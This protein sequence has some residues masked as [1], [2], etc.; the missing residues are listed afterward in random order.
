[1]LYDH[2]LLLAYGS[3]ATPQE[4]K[5]YFESLIQA[6]ELAPDRLAEQMEHIV[7]IGG[8]VPQAK[9]V[10]KL[11]EKLEKLLLA[12]GYQV[13]VYFGMRHGQPPITNAL[14]E[15]KKRKGIRG[16]AVILSPH[17]SEMT[18]ERYTQAVDAA[19]NAVGAQ[20]VQYEYL[21]VKHNHPLFIQAWVDQARQAM[22]KLT[23]EQREFVHIVFTGRAIPRSIAQL[24]D[25]EKEVT[26]TTV[27]VAKDLAHPKWTLAYQSR[28][29]A[30]KETCTEPEISS[31]IALFNKEKER[32]VLVVP[33][34]L[35]A[36]C[37]ETRYDL[38]VDSR[39]KA[40]TGG[41]GFM[42]ADTPI[43][44]PKFVLSILDMLVEKLK[45]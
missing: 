24:S 26:A 21:K 25:Y 3:P 5:P 23:L 6:K 12:L 30:G 42:R 2:V 4:V 31:V 27:Q 44:H 32:H 29:D 33:V 36:E 19:R 28:M 34:G 8:S 1:M 40:E 45:G 14:K 10:E 15:V 16:L 41:Y 43:E 9:V 37:L 22:R 17:K 7:K 11:A 13:P 38:D 20:S 39:K 35:V 18:Y